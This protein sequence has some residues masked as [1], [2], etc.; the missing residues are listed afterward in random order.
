MRDWLGGMVAGNFVE[1]DPAGE[2]YW[3]THEA[4]E[5]LKTE[6]T[7][8]EMVLASFIPTLALVFEKICDCFK[9]DGPSGMLVILIR[10]PNAGNEIFLH[11]SVRNIDPRYILL[12]LRANTRSNLYYF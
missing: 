4:K 5:A 7:L 8:E 3:M 1:C 2:T 11:N 9:L 12:R 10:P 6:D